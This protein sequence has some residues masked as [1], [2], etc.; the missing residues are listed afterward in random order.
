MTYHNP[1]GESLSTHQLKGTTQGFEHCSMRKSSTGIGD[2]IYL[3][4]YIY[5]CVYEIQLILYI[6]L[7]PGCYGIKV[8]F[9]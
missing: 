6:K 3:Y 1:L 2:V 8:Q 7:F 5:L 9:W 4:I